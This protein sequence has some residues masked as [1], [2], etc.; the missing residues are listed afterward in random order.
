M[1]FRSLNKLRRLCLARYAPV[2][3][4]VRLLCVGW[5][6]HWRVVCWDVWLQQSCA[7]HGVGVVHLCLCWCSIPVVFLY[8]S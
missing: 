3:L 6:V 1:P 8:L 2:H 7:L 5:Y 4:V